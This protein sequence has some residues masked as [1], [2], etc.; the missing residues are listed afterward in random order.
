MQQHFY[1]LHIPKTSGTSLYTALYSLFDKSQIFPNL[2]W[3]EIA[4]NEQRQQ[5]VA[6]L[7]NDRYKF[8]VG[9]YGNNHRIIKNRFVFSMFRNPVYR[10]LSQLRHI[11]R[12]PIIN[13]WVNGTDWF[14]GNDLFSPLNN[15]HF[16][17]Y[18]SDVQS[19]YLLANVDPS[20]L[21]LDQSI[22]T[23]F[24]FDQHPKVVKVTA[25]SNLIIILKLLKAL[26]QLDFFGI[27][28]LHDESLILL[29]HQL[30]KPL[31]PL[32][33]RR[34]FDGTTT[35]S[36]NLTDEQVE[37]LESINQK[38]KLLYAMAKKLFIRRWLKYLR[39]QHN[40]QL[41]YYDY[42]RNRASIL[43]KLMV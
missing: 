4:R 35:E 6:D 1:F 21:V 34:M 36:M 33:E 31:R 30:N 18:I 42:L 26:R 39:Q 32:N 40:L 8:I 10:T 17:N 22:D 24:F 5:L 41:T 25:G 12:D 16:A 13:A 15:P 14:T 29:S 37:I 3:M 7:Y 27:K 28:E 11:K 20:S 19:R 2:T 23:H 9:H 38:D 43:Q